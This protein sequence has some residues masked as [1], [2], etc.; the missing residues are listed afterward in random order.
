MRRR[1]WAP[2]TSIPAL[3]NIYFVTKIDLPKY[4]IHHP[5]IRSSSRA[6]DKRAPIASGSSGSSVIDANGLSIMNVGTYVQQTGVQ[7][8]GI[9]IGVISDDVTSLSVIQGRAELPTVNVIYP[10]ANPMPHID[11]TDEGTMMLEE[12]YAVAPNANLAFCGPESGVEYA[13]CLTNLIAAGATV[14]S[15]DLQYPGYDVMSS[16]AQNGPGQDVEAILA[17][18][19]SVMLFHAVGNDAQDYWQGPYTPWHGTPTSCGA[20]TDNY[21]QQFGASS[22]ISWQTNGGKTL[23]LASNL[24][25]NP[26]SLNDFDVYLVDPATSQIVACGTAAN[27]G[28]SGATSYTAIDGN[29]IPQGN[30]YIYVGTPDASLAG[31]YLKLIGSDDGGGTFVPVTIGSP[32]SPQDFAAGVITVGAV[33]GIDGIGD[34]IELYSDTGPI[35]TVVPLPLIIQAP[36]AVAPDDIYVDTSGTLFAMQEYDAE[37]TGTSAASPNAAAVAALLRSAFPTLTPTQIT[38]YMEAGAVQLGTS[39]WNGTFGYGRVDAMGALSMIPA[40]TIAAP[41]SPT[42]VGGSSSPALP[43]TIGGTGV[44]KVSAAP[45][46]SLI[47]SGT[48][49]VISPSTCGNPTTSCTITLTP[50]IGLTGSVTVQVTV[51]DGSNRSQSVQVPV[52]VTAP[53]KPTITITGGGTQSV[54]V[55]SAIAPVT[56]KVGGTGPLTF[57]YNTNDVTSISVT[58][59]CGTTTMSC[60]ATLGAAEGVAGTATLSLTVEDSYFQSSAATA[61]IT[62]TAPPSGSGGGGGALDRWTLLALGGAALIRALAGR[63]ETRPGELRSCACDRRPGVISE[64]M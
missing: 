42:I 12:V 11:P 31:V 20:Q 50:A 35:Q 45:S 13:A 8:A 10:S 41:Q 6:T 55:N 5:P 49:V 38:G 1:G 26:M 56:F 61:T 18:S 4:A 9:T 52:T 14:I 34:N 19:P 15:D 24:P 23:A 57:I 37:F 36:L 29:V 43:F 58:P 40:P 3:A 27:G 62:V 17:A 63:R 48:G 30:L 25:P 53:P 44:L 64:R 2:L 60:I 22:F 46:T 51:T 39:P 28:I 21:Y 16:P 47:P 33:D 32:G 7:G 54:L 59:G